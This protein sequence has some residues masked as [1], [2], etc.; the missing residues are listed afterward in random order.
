MDVG[1]LRPMG[2]GAVSLRTL[3]LFRKSLVLVA[4]RRARA[5]LLE[6]G[7][8]VVLWMGWRRLWY[9][10]RIRPRGLGPLGSLR[11]LPAVVWPRLLRRLSKRRFQ[12]PH[13]RCEQYQHHECVSQRPRARRLHRS[14]W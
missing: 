13:T 14:G 4:G 12:Q 6:A 11:G 1:E 2:L 8:S 9:R 5:A 3:V 7:A 10:H